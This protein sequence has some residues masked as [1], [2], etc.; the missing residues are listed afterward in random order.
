MPTSIHEYQ[1]P[2]QIIRPA[3]DGALLSLH[4]RQLQLKEPRLFTWEFM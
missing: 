2:L 1:R 4:K 3:T